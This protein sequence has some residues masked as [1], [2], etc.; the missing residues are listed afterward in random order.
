[1]A[2]PTEQLHFL[3]PAGFRAGGVYAGIK[4]KQTNDVGVLAVDDP[5]GA[6][7]A[8]MFTANVVAAA[9]ILVG[10]V[11][12]EAGR[13][14]AIVINSGNANACT[15]RKGVEDAVSMCKL[16]SQLLGCETE[17]VLPSS[18][19]IIGHNLPMEKV[20][21]GIRAAAADLG[22]DL[23]HAEAFNNA[24]LTT[25]TRRKFAAAQF[26][27]GR[28]TVTVTGI[29][30]GAGMIGPRMIGPP[31][32]RVGRAKAKRGAQGTMLA[33]LLTDADVTGKQLQQV[34][35]AATETTFNNV[36][37]DNHTS[38]NDTAVMLASGAS[39]AKVSEKKDF[40]KFAQA[41]EDV[42]ESLARQIAADG[43][44]ATKLVTVVVKRGYDDQHARQIARTIADS[45]LLKCALH[46][47]DPNWGRI[48]SAAGY[49]GAAFD[50][51]RATCK[52]QGTVVFRNGTPVKFDPDAVS[53]SMA[54]PEVVIELDCRL[55]DG[56]ATVW[57]CDF[58]KDYVTINADYHT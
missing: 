38:T 55:N 18:T 56:S 8:A 6:A 11:H 25:D 20:Y 31:G 1:M 28:K 12:V 43:E 23:A 19:G 35:S 27:V 53:K 41:V 24:I 30:K 49:S 36:T 48:V 21:L 26:K 54:A 4:R 10:R 44:G 22:N 3:T 13:L 52:L 50:P 51:D 5:R 34:L 47:N 17:D 57:T 33:Y 37:I 9:P 58:S 14:R 2:E 32:L 29:C 46:G 40:I 42:C 39:G 16:T 45:P 15:G 7:A